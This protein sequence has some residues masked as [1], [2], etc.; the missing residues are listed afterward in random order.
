M[1]DRRL[2]SSAA[3]SA[4]LVVSAEGD[5]VDVFKTRLEGVAMQNW[6]LLLI[7]KTSRQHAEMPNLGGRLVKRVE[8]RRAG[9]VERS[10][11]GGA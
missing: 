9:P 5:R 10:A 8:V 2:A 1:N 6:A 3:H 11:E 7:Q 4:V